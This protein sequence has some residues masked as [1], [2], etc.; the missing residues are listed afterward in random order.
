MTS[1]CPGW[2]RMQLGAFTGNGRLGEQT[3]TEVLWS[4]W[5]L[6]EPTLFGEAVRLTVISYGGGVQSTAMI[7]LAVGLPIAGAE[8]TTLSGGRAGQRLG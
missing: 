3:R 6:G 4:N 8:K 7:V 2:S 5:P 1:T